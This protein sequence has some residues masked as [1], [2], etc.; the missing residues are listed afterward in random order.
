M[1][2]RAQAL[3]C[4]HYLP[5]R[6]IT[7]EELSKK[8]DTSDEWIRSRTG[9]GQRH[10]AAETEKTSDLGTAAADRALSHAGI[11]AGDLDAIIVATATPD[12]TFPST[13]TR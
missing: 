11:S 9:I 12:Q 1:T 7:N 3:G 4:G 13:A 2:I 5:D 6:V 10:I 8:L